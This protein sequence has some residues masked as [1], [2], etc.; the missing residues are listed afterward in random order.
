ME[1]SRQAEALF[2]QEAD[3]VQIAQEARLALA[4]PV[5]GAAGGWGWW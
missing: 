1:L 4:P 2:P 5:A 3:V